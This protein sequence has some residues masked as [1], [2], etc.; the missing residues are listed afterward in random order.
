M[1]CIIL[2]DGSADPV[3]VDSCGAD[4]F[5]AWEIVNHSVDWHAAQHAEENGTPLTP[6]S[7]ALL[8]NTQLEY[9]ALED[10]IEVLI[11]AGGVWAELACGGKLQEAGA[12]L[13]DVGYTHV[14]VQSRIQYTKVQYVP[15]PNETFGQMTCVKMP[16]RQYPPKIKKEARKA[17]RDNL[18]ILCSPR[19]CALP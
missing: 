1:T 18:G 13:L 2:D 4:M 16:C 19:W 5:P 11:N 7:R 17:R 9:W 6:E 8:W 14:I 12:W 10:S 15:V 3:L